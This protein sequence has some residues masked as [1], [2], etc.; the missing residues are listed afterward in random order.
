MPVGLDSR[1]LAC[2]GVNTRRVSFNTACTW[3]TVRWRARRATDNLTVL[4]LLK[5]IITWSSIGSEVF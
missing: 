1:K 4:E 2:K 5:L 3:C